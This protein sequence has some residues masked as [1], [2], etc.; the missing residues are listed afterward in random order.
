MKP[1]KLEHRYYVAKVSDAKAALTEE[2]LA[3]LEELMHKVEFNRRLF[4]KP[5]LVGV[6][7][8]ND[9]VGYSKVLDMVRKLHE[10]EM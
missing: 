4:R 9:W 2:E 8:E 7:Y 5:P 3:K 1:F 6:F 10:G